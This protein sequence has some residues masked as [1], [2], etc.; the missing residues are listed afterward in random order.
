M[1]ALDLFTES[2]ICPADGKDAPRQTHR[3]LP[4]TH[5]LASRQSKNI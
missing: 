2:T 3:E 1:S 5:A 4:D